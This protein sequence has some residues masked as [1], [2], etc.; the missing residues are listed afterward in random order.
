MDNEIYFDIK[1]IMKKFIKRN[2]W[3]HYTAADI[4]Y[5]HNMRS[6]RDA[7]LTFIDSFYGDS[8]GV[9]LFN[10]RDGFNYVHDIFTASNP[11]QMMIADCDSICPVFVSESELTLEEIGYLNS[12][13]IKIALENNLIIYRFKRGYDKRLATLA[14]EREVFKYIEF[15]DSLLRNDKK[16]IEEAFK[17]DYVA[18]CDIDFKDYEYNLIP[19]PVPFLEKSFKNEKPNEAIYLELKDKLFVN[20][21]AVLFTAYLPFFVDTPN[22]WERIRPLGVYLVY[23]ALDKVYF[24][25]IIDDPSGYSEKLWTIIYDAFTIIGKPAMITCN[26]RDVYASLKN[27]FK[28]LNIELKRDKN[29]YLKYSGLHSLLARFYQEE[30][31][32]ATMSPKDANELLRAYMETVNSMNYSETEL[33]SYDDSMES[34]ESDDNNST[35]VS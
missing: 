14:E 30:L 11:D 17:L 19:R 27:T 33:D 29:E 12:R 24:G 32:E 4:F 18:Y 25:Y 20:D 8:F 6:K 26:G 13:N 2:C 34:I 1:K 7:F 10:N 23:P 3:E 16:I 5:F 22:G 9:Q 15:L 35:L 31:I 28:K 21:E